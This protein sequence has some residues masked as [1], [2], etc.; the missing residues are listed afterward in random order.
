MIAIKKSTLLEET[1]G[2]VRLKEENFK[3]ILLIQEL[4]WEKTLRSMRPIKMI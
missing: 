3:N 4:K 2:K 1:L